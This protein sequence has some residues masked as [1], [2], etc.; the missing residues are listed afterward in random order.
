MEP[1]KDG[2]RD[3]LP[4]Y[5]VPSIQCGMRS[6][7]KYGVRSTEYSVV[8]RHFSSFC[9]IM[10]GLTL[11]AFYSTHEWFSYDV[12]PCMLWGNQTSHA[13][14]VIYHSWHLCGVKSWQV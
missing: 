14:A 10:M 11:F 3:T 2:G 13:V 7:V 1:D 5:S 4:R 9:T 12:T 8:G 6:Q